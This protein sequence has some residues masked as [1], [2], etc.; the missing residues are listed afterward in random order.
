MFWR[1][2]W[3]LLCASR[4]RLAAG[5][6]RGDQRR[7]GLRGVAESGSGRRRQADAGISHAR[8]ER[9]RLAAAR[10]ATHAGYD[11]RRACI[12]LASPRCT[13]RKSWPP[14]LIFT[15]SRRPARA[16]DRRPVIVAG[17]WFDQVARMNSWWKVEGQ[18]VSQRD[19]QRALHGRARGR[20]AAWPG[21]RQPRQVALR[22]P[23]GAAHRRG[24]R[25]RGRRRRQSDLRRACRRRRISPACRP[26]QPGAAE[27]AR[28]GAE[29]EDVDRAASPARCRDSRCGR[30]ANSPQ[31]RAAC[32]SAFAGCCSRPSLLI[33]AL[34]AL[35]VLASM[36]GLALERRRDVGLMKAL[37]GTVRRM[38]RFFLAE[39]TAHRHRR[40][41]RSASAWACCSRE[42]IGER[43]FG[44]A[45]SPRLIVLPIDRWR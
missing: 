5:A 2:L 14:R 3:R 29:I 18:W 12:E 40:R 17:T 36:A 11:G 39:A 23:G 26:H 41:H 19:D 30:C 6:D 34:T 8:R 21:S 45:I 43:V 25:D 20:A 35:G 15:S 38:M 10:P 33:L 9:G 24:R 27:R 1:I 31:P 32:S 16:S 13:R 37:G 42:W 7:G 44:A 22:R 28:L 4:G